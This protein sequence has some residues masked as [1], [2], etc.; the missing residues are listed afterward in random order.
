MVEHVVG[1]LA[2]A[3]DEIVVVTSES[4]ALPPLSSYGARIVRDRQ[5]AL[6]PL[7]GIRDGLAALES[8]A[9][10]AF[11]TS[12]DAPFL[13]EAF[14]GALLDRNCACAPLAEGFVQ[15]LS[16][17]Y[18][19]AGWQVADRLLGEGAGRPLQLLE[20]VGYE[21]V[22]CGPNLH[23]SGFGTG[24]PAWHGFNTPQAYLE[25]VREVDPL[26][27]AEVELVGRAFEGQASPRM[28][29]PV[30]TLGEVLANWPE[31]LG[32]VRDGVVDEGFRVSLGG[33][34]IVQ[35]L[36]VPVGPGES[37]RVTQVTSG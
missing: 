24:R 20:S 14:V 35:D 31:S 10:F 23:D 29:V 37:V 2:N 9:Q 15:V 36:K 12:T 33:N 21:A 17:V 6:G 28:K 7:A 13:T 1:I 26:A 32:L 18:P 4:L 16:A 34:E 11:V 5:P 30:G 19:K 3:V 27:K 22:D 25:A 8:D